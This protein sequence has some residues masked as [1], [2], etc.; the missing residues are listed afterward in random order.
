MLSATVLVPAHNEETS[1]GELIRACRGQSYPLDEIVVVA[2]SCTDDTAGR[3][4]AAGARV[5]EVDC[6]DKATAQNTV[7]WEIESDVIIGFDGD[8]Q[9]TPDCIE[10]LM[11]DLN[12]RGYDAT[13]ATI[14]PLQPRGFFIRARRFS[15]S[16]G[17]RWWR[18]CQ[19]EVGRIQVLTGAAYAFRTPVIKGVGGFPSGLISADMDA[20]WAMHAAGYKLGYAAKAIALTVDPES[21]SVWRAQMRRWASGYAQNM[22]KYRR[23]VLHPRSLLVVGTALFDLVSLFWSYA[24]FAYLFATGHGDKVAAVYGIYFAIHILVNIGLVASVVGIREA[25]LGF[26]PWLIVNWYTRW[27]YLAALFR[28]WILGRHYASWT[29]R[30][31]RATVITPMT[32]RRKLALTALT[33]VAAVF[34]TAAWLA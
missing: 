10:L 22:A 8:T 20:T 11:A 7:L 21:F 1:I 24:L 23:H 34:A 18:L 4:R 32:S 5:V 19:A 26:L 13:C 6:Q 25:V 2:D 17:R 27:L 14:L 12:E 29:G 3:A 33:A 16:L 31:G 28:E 9:P 15:Y 30:Q